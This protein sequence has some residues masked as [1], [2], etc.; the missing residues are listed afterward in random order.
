MDLYLTGGTGFIG[1]NLLASGAFN[2]FNVTLLVRKEPPPD[3]I[4]YPYILL[5]DFFSKSFEHFSG[6]FLHAATDYGRQGNIANV[7]N[8]NLTLPMSIVQKLEKNLMGLV[9]LDTYY[10]KADYQYPYLLN[11]SISKLYFHN[12]SKLAFPNL[13][14][15]RL[16]LE[17]V[18]G[19]DDRLDKFVP[20]LIQKAKLNKDMELSSGYQIR[21]FV[22][23]KDVA[24]AISIVLRKANF[25][26]NLNETFEI[27]T[28][29]GTSIAD[30]AKL[31]FKIAGANSRLNF[32][33]IPD[34]DQE[35]PV[36]VANLGNLK[37]LGFEPSISLKNGLEMMITKKQS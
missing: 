27:G 2:D 35:I 11:Y 21:D 13:S 1:K 34:R 17:H 8:A 24:N 3:L 31:V 16:I 20:N 32:G 6:F 15:K 37:S 5:G 23:V 22:H 19:P 7:I 36:S 26:T 14:K 33:S 18:Y 29:V 4:A 28:G 10:N 30:F 12:W 9:Y 25:S